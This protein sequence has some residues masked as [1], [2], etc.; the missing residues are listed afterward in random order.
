MSE[1]GFERRANELKNCGEEE[2]L[3]I[4]G[5]V[6]VEILLAAVSNEIKRLKKLEADMKNLFAK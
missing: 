4:L 1:I 3:K 5:T 2:L 6:D